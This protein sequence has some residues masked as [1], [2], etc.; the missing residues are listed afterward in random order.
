MN[1]TDTISNPN[2]FAVI[3][4]SSIESE[5]AQPA[6]KNNR[7]GWVDFGAKNDYP[8]QIID[9]IGKSPVNTAIIGS[10]VTYMCGKG[11]KETLKANEEVKLIGAPNPSESWDEVFE[12]LAKDYKM[13][14]GFYFQVVKNKDDTTVSIFHQDFS[15]VRIG[16]ISETGEP[17]TFRISNDWKKTSGK[18]K[19]IELNA[20]NGINNLKKGEAQMFFH[21]DYISGLSHYCLPDYHSSLEYAKA[22]GALAEFF[23]NSINN[24]FTP[25]VVISMPS[26]PDEKKKADFQKKMERAFSGAKG[27]SSIV[28]LW[29]E[30]DEVKPVITPFQA[31]ANANIYNEIEGIIFQKIISSHRLSSPTLAGISGKGNLSGNAAEIVDSFVLFNYTV[32][33]KLKRKILDKLNIFTK[34]NGTAELV[35]AELDVVTKIRETEKPKETLNVKIENPKELKELK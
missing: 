10:I 23:N 12:K 19:P 3:N 15:K 32:I 7:A 30:N 26:N 9:I 8:Q 18:N 14:G 35:I 5:S 11:I 24:G 16:Q 21:F 13:F 6:M 28:I 31:S 34:I 4:L 2:N 20:W 1:A 27:A 29:G 17:L 33:E 22:D 25:S